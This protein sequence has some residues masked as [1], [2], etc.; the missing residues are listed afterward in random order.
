MRLTPSRWALSLAVLGTAGMAA[1][2]WSH[3]STAEQPRTR[4]AA[5]LVELLREPKLEARREAASGLAKLGTDAI[6]ALTPLMGA[7]AD[8]DPLVRAEAAVA[9]GRIGPLA[10]PRLTASL[11]D[12]NPRV[13]RGVIQSLG[14]LGPA[15]A[16]ALPGL[17]AAL[18]S[19]DGSIRFCAVRALG[20]IGP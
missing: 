6:V 8:P 13:R 5:D 12:P 15:A 3:R 18:R 1:Y 7:L 19:D 4:T 20:Q 2:L 9:L 10:L 11:D 17:I 16:P 14:L